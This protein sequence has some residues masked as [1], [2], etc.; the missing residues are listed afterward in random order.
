MISQEK[1]VSSLDGLKK[2]DEWILKIENTLGVSFDDNGLTIRVYNEYIALLNDALELRDGDPEFYDY[3]LPDIFW[4]NPPRQVRDM[5][6]MEHGKVYVP[7]YDDAESF[8]NY[9]V[10][11]KCSNTSSIE[12]FK[13]YNVKVMVCNG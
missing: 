12:E 1:F 2:F 4:S 3:F 6:F 5:P 7:Y 9:I 10:W 13:Y 8:Y 11:R